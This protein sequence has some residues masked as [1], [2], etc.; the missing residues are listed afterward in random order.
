MENFAILQY[1]FIKLYFC[2]G[3][4]KISWD[5]ANT[6]SVGLA[7]K[8]GLEYDSTYDAYNFI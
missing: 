7:Q 5:A 1:N 4:K 2:G 8:L 6:N 3:N